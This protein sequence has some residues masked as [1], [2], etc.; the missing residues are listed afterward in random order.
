ML[1]HFKTHSQG[2]KRYGIHLTID[3]KIKWN[4]SKSREIYY[5]PSLI[6]TQYLLNSLKKNLSQIMLID[7]SQ[8]CHGQKIINWLNS[9]GMDMKEM[10][11]NHLL[12]LQSY[13]LKWAHTLKA[14]KVLETNIRKYLPQH[15]IDRVGKIFK[16][17]SENT[18]HNIYIYI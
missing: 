3:L 16:K 8:C 2:I 12:F 10:Y 9:G 11:L 6:Y 7:F 13:Y 4:N 5:S 14:V 18:R 15:R 1:I 17:N